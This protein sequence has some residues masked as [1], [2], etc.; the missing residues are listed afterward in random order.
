VLR[1]LFVAQ[2]TKRGEENWLGVF[3]VRDAGVAISTEKAAN[4]VGIV[5]VIEMKALRLSSRLGCAANRTPPS[6]LSQEIG[7]GSIRNAVNRLEINVVSPI[8]KIAI[9]AF[10]IFSTAFAIFL[11]PFEGVSTFFVRVSG[12]PTRDLRHNLVRISR[13]PFSARLVLASFAGAA[14]GGLRFIAAEIRDSFSFSTLGAG[15]VFHDPI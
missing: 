1:L 14:S 6:L 3:E 7:I 13:F 10:R 5:A 2:V 9:V 11:C 8:G 15:S 4:A 12:D